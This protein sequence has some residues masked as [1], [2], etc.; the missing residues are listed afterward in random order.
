MNIVIDSR[1][2]CRESPTGKGAWA[3]SFLKELCTRRDVSCT[4]LCEEGQ[5]KDFTFPGGKMVF[6]PRGARWHFAAMA[7]LRSHPCDFFLSPTSYIVPAFVGKRVR[8]VPII[9]DLIA[10]QREPHDRKARVI[11]RILLP[12]VLKNAAHLYTVSESTKNDLLE[13]FP[14]LDSTKI[15]V[16]SA[17]PREVNPPL[18]KSDGKTVLSLGTLCPRKNQLGL[19]RAFA[20]LPENI[21]SSVRLILVGNRG[22]QD[23]EI[24][25]KAKST[26]GV[27]WKGYLSEHEVEQLFSSCHV[28]ALPSFYEG[29]GLA[30]LEALQ[31]GI[32]VL[33]SDRG[34]LKE[35]AGD[36]ALYCDP[37][38]PASITEGLITLLTDEAVRQK[39]S[40]AG[41]AQAARFSWGKTVD[42]TL[43]ALHH[44]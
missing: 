20:M 21:R 30:V 4:L 41:R 13:K 35:I 12:R 24:I 39:L 6:L 44:L 8:T 7:Y 43:A 23:D 28:F 27:E 1:E 29:F 33:T 25:K 2:A 14:H 15:T 18:A 40:E 9:H 36:G 26:P 5:E 34:G 42:L 3:A 31:R 32:P 16:I 38:N 22:W 37:G 10:F 17:G 19:I 11:E